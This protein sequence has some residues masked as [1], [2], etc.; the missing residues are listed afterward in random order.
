M[1]SMNGLGP[2]GERAEGANSVVLAETEIAAARRKQYRVAIVMHTLNSD[3]S[4]LQLA[5]IVGTLG[6]C[7]CVVSEVVD[8]QFNAQTQISALSQLSSQPLDAIISIPVANTDVAEAHRMVSRSGIHLILLDNVPTGL[9]PGNDYVSLVSSDNFGLGIISAQL[10]ADKLPQDA[11]I[12][13][14]TYSEDFYAI[15]EREIAFRRWMKLYRP[16]LTLE[17]ESFNA[18]ELAGQQA[19][20]LLKSHPNLSGIF[21][22]WDTP[23]MSA[24]NA[25]AKIQ[26]NIQVTTVDLGHEASLKLAQGK[27]LIGIAAQQ[28]YLLGVAAAHTGVLAMLGQVVPRWIAL[29]GL[30]VTQEN[31]V[32]RY[33]EVWRAPASPE[34]IQAR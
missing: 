31:V 28:P 20:A 3:W 24:L 33:Q 9:L 12:G 30:P 4:R 2:H 1:M 16:D 23:A 14:L 13:M 5:G 22:V 10:L 6:D 7:G 29:P 25:L 21:A 11:I 15:N 18:P 32:T 8:C 26:T 34:I 27:S 19:L 17:T